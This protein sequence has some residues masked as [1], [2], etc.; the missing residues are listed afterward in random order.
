M[1]I[2]DTNIVSNFLRDRSSTSRLRQRIL[3]TSPEQLFIT[4]ITV[5]EI[6]RGALNQIN[7]VRRNTEVVNA[8][9]RFSALV[10]AV[11]EFQILPYTE[12]AQQIFGTLPPGILRVGRQDCR[13]AAIAKSRGFVIVTAN[14][15]D[16]EAI[17]LAPVEDW[18]L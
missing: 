13:I 10:N 2:L 7:Q 15:T 8:Y 12:E 14:V 18:T 11:N 4:V 1:Y 3:D 16:F 17:G 6:L 5:E 9:A